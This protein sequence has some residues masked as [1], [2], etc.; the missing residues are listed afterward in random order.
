[1]YR[2]DRMGLICGLNAYQQ[3]KLGHGSQLQSEGNITIDSL[4][5]LPIG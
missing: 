1:M 5:G 2:N 3:L 4:K